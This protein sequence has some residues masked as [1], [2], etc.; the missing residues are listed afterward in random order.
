MCFALQLKDS[1][2]RVPFDMTDD[3]DMRTL[4]GGAAAPSPL[5][6]PPSPRVSS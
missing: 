5:L 6:A 4:L 3:K 2:G 1:F